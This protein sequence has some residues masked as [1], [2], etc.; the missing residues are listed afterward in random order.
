MATPIA[1]N[2]D[3]IIPNNGQIMSITVTVDTTIQNTSTRDCLYQTT[4]TDNIWA[5]ASTTEGIFIPL[6]K[7]LYLKS[8]G[9]TIT[10]ARIEAT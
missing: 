5:K 7:T 8:L 9:H 4:E 6:G 2:E 3:I 1:E 10:F